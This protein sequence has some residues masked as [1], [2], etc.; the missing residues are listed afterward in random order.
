M[1]CYGGR[2]LRETNIQ[3]LAPYIFYCFSEYLKIVDY[4]TIHYVTCAKKLKLL[5][6][7]ISVVNTV[8]FIFLQIQTYIFQKF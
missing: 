1:H 3:L 5:Q 7:Q 2:A 8:K 6:E 4:F